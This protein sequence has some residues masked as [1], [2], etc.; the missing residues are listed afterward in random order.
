MIGKSQGEP[1]FPVDFY[2][3]WMSLLSAR[4]SLLSAVPGK[5]WL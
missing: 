1:P 5:S 3:S 4:L 2:L